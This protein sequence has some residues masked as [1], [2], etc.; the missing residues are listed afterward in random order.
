MKVEHL[1]II[2][3]A[4]WQA[5][6]TRQGTLVSKGT[7]VPVWDRR[8]P[9]TLFSGLM[10]C[11]CCGSGFA[12]VSKDSF[13][14]SA[15]RNKGAAICSNMRVIKQKV[16]EEAVLNALAHQLMDPEAVEVF[17]KEYAA[18]RNR[19]AK[20]ADAGRAELE[21]ELAQ[22]K[23]DHAKLVDAILAGIPADQV[24]EKMLGLD[25][26]R[27]ELEARLSATDRPDPLRFHPGMAQTYRARVAALIRGLGEAEEME[28]AKE[29]IRGLIDAIVLTPPEDGGPGLS[30]DLHGA[31]AGLLRLASGLPVGAGGA[32]GA[33]I[34]KAPRGA[35]LGGSSSVGSG[36]ADWQAFDT[37]GELV[38]VAGAGNRRWL[39]APFCLV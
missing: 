6:R 26:R 7:D 17:C 14:C 34:Q 18:E 13:G 8:R 16:L 21:T 28:L 27:K 2:D 30:L 5:A 39:P 15:A 3:E 1:R 23:R 31:L 38:L 33:G 37:A 4:L 22:V 32:A 25:A 20:K 24:K 9:R 35:G 12:K 29:A 10:K 11:G 36:G 19:L